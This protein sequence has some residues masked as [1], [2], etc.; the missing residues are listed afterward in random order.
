MPWAQENLA[1]SV[2]C[3]D[4]KSDQNVTNITPVYIEKSTMPREIDLTL[5]DIGLSP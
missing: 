1:G 4:D 5:L 2:C 3:E